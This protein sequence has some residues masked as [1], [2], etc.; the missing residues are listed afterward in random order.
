MHAGNGAPDLLWGRG[1]ETGGKEEGTGKKD[2]ERHFGKTGSLKG[3]AL[4]SREGGG[5]RGTA[6]NPTTASSQSERKEGRLGARE[7]LSLATRY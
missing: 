4:E 5:Q 7:Q 1:P 6:W 3:A 2:E